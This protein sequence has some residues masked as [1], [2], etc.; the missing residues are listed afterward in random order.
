VLALAAVALGLGIWSWPS[1][2]REGRVAVMVVASALVL[3]GLIF[4][5][6]VSVEW[7]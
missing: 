6:A 3:G 1:G 5:V 7:Q 2:S 4:L